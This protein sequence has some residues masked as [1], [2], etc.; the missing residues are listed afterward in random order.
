MAMRDRITEVKQKQANGSFT[1]WIPIGALAQ[2]IEVT[3]D[4]SIDESGHTDL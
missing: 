3:V 1:D 4:T 2:D